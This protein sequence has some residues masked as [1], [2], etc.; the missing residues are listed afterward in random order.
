ME[1][2]LCYHIF[3]HANGRENLF[4]EQRNYNFFLRR[5]QFH[6]LPV[7]CMYA[8][9]LMKNHFHLFVRIRTEK[10]LSALWNKFQTQLTMERL[11]LKTSKAFSNLFS[12]Y[13]QSF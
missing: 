3:N 12:S 5:I 7:C 8:Y 11:I 13:T 2:G 6:V 1:P 10:E 4:V 9:C